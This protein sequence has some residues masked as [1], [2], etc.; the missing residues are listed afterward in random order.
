VYSRSTRRAW[1]F[2]TVWSEGWGDVTLEG[3]QANEG[4]DRSLQTSRARHYPELL[5]SRWSA[6]T[7]STADRTECG[8]AVGSQMQRSNELKRIPVILKRSLRERNNWRIRLG[9][10]VG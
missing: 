6:R 2:K 10:V 5:F 3:F 9:L 1:R 4:A 8:I 7:P